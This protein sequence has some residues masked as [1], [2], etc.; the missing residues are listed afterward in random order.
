[1]NNTY[2]VWK[3]AYLVHKMVNVTFEAVVEYCDNYSEKN[4]GDWITASIDGDNRNVLY[5]RCVEAGEREVK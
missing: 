4:A 1:M 5:K 2:K 3:N